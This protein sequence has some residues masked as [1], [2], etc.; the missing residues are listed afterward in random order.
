M[1]YSFLSASTSS[2]S[3]GDAIKELIDD[4]VEGTQKIIFLPPWLIRIG[5]VFLALI[6]SFF[7][8][9]MG[10]K[11]LRN[12]IVNPS[13]NPNR[14]DKRTLGQKETF[15]SLAT[16]IFS[17]LMYFII[18]TIILSML[19]I[20]ISSILAIAGVSGVAIGFGAQTL[21]KDII[22]GVFLWSEGNVTVGEKITVNN[23]HGVVEAVTLRT[24]KIRDFNGNLYVV[25]N[26]D[27]RTVINTS[28]DFKRAIIDMRLSYEEDLNYMLDIIEQELVLADKQLDYILET[29]TIMGINAIQSDCIILRI[30]ALCEETAYNAVEREIRKRL[31]LRFKEENII[32]PHA[33]AIATPRLDALEK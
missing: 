25:P 18:A 13:R 16:N 15:A 19:G 32:V 27:I 14:N 30:S 22:S 11:A 26:G 33:P 9:R 6:L 28:R 12:F 1:F 10:R 20:N 8:L 5:I 3:T 29:P 24:T 4:A 7:L 31:L 2:P 21:V 23:M 17:Y